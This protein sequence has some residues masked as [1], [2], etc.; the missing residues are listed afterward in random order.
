MYIKGTTITEEL[1][2]TRKAIHRQ[3][4]KGDGRKGDLQMFIFFLHC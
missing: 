2:M 1:Q 4:E 3:S